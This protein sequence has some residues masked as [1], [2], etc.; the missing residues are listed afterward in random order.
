[1]DKLPRWSGRKI[2]RVFKKAGWIVDRIEGS[3]H[4]LVKE[5][6]EEILSVPVHGTKPIKVGLLKGLIKDAGLT[7]EEFLWLCY[8]KRWG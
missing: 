8:K 1:M 3:H 4:I 7:N 2:I 6:A 5:G